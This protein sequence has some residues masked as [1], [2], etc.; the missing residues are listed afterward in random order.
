MPK[1]L[2]KVV[3]ILLF[4]VFLSPVNNAYSA[5]DWDFKL[6]PFAWLTSISG[7]VTAR[8]MENEVDVS[9][10]DIWDTLNFALLF[11]FE[12][13]YKEKYGFYISPVYMKLKDERDGLLF[14]F[15]SELDSLI[16]EGGFIYNLLNSSTG[17]GNSKIDFLLGGRLWYMDVNL[18]IEGPMGG[19]T[20]VNGDKTWFDFL[21]G[22]RFVYEYNKF[23]FVARTDLGGFNLGFSSDISWNIGAFVGYEVFDNIT[24]FI[25]YR[26]LYADYD[27]GSG[28]DRFAYDAWTYGPVLGFQF[29][30]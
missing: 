26:A 7:D 18:D 16:L 29:A 13:M 25:G 30:F 28:N 27:D 22:L 8:G 12:A 3:L 5:E 21:T 9:F 2:K 4:S 23:A 10:G 1:N 17:N 24:P 14:E 19:K 15:D 11:E 20:S 6:T